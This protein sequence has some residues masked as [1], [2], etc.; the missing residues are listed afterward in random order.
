MNETKQQLRDKVAELTAQLELAQKSREDLRQ[1]F[2]RLK[3]KLKAAEMAD[4]EHAEKYK[5]VHP[6]NAYWMNNSDAYITI[7]TT[8]YTR[9][10]DRLPDQR[11]C[12]LPIPN[13]TGNVEW[14]IQ[15]PKEGY[16]DDAFVSPHWERIKTDDEGEHWHHPGIKTDDRTFSERNC[17]IESRE[18]YRKR[19]AREKIEAIKKAAQLAQ[20]I[21]AFYQE[22][23]GFPD[24]EMSVKFTVRC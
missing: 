2:V 6:E 14:H 3:G 23:D 17:L 15:L 20:Q 8:R 7:A 12:S 16:G 19:H 18:Q 22:I 5:T 21:E 4:P 1:K 11:V 24:E 10:W 9:D 13:I